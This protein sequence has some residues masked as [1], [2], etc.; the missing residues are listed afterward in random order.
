MATP[1]GLDQKKPTP[2]YALPK[3]PE[4]PN[5]EFLTIQETAY[6]FNCSVKSIRRRLA[7]GAFAS[8]PGRSI[9]LSRADRKALYEMRR[10]GRR[11]GAGRRPAQT[12]NKKTTAQQAP[13][14]STTASA[15]A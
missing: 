7:E 8:R 9:M 4:D 14:E 6:V 15:A 2:A 13:P 12:A 1:T 5:A 11:K 3:K 10:S